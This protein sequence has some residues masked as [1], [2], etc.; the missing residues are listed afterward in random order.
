MNPRVKLV[1]LCLATVVIWSLTG[2][3][4]AG[5]GDDA[6]SRA[7]TWLATQ[8]NADGGFS[9]GFSPNSKLSSTADA[10]LA[11]TAAGQDASTW[12]RGGVSPLDYLQRQAG[13][14]T[15]SGE[16]GKVILAVA[17]TGGDPHH[18]S[19]A[20]LV[21]RLNGLHKSGGYGGTLY[22]DTLAVLALA[23]A[24]QNVPD[25]V[26]ARLLQA[27]T[28]D[29]AWA[30]T[31]DTASGAGDTNTT[32]LVM[33]AL[34]ATGRRDA[35]GRAL[36]YF[37][38]TQN[39]DAGWP[40]QAPSA[41]GTETDAN[42][43]ANVLQALVASGESP[44]NWSKSGQSDPLGALIHLQDDKTGAFNFQA[45]QPGAN[46]LA[47][48]Q[49]VPALKGATWVRVPLVPASSAA[50]TVTAPPPQTLPVAGG[51]LSM[52]TPVLAGIGVTLV[53]AGW[54]VRRKA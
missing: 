1:A 11:I 22:E 28:A 29:G 51:V 47:T 20:D 19:G 27:Q 25:D 7:L 40:Y 12:K 14:T 9:D 3:A 2:P 43:T 49:A 42:S 41:Y 4:L 52:L 26:M 23:N 45:S 6:A 33:Q 8:Q 16:I 31:G 46:L 54:W 13:Q 39:A 44:S 21:A 37:R 15:N 36:D 48:L 38:R 50:S 35:L 17:A 32:A 10:I 5:P 34:V 18:W 30:F 53:L 24:G